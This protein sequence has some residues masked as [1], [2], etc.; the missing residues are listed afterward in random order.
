MPLFVLILFFFVANLFAAAWTGSTSEPENTVKVGGKIFYAITS[1]EELAWFAIQVNA[2]TTT[3]N[4]VLQ[5]D[6]VFGENTN[7]VG[8]SSWTPIGK[9]MA[10]AFNGIFDGAHHSIYGLYS[11]VR[12]TSGFIGVLNSNGVLKDISFYKGTLNAD[13]V[14]GLVGVNKGTVENVVNKS[15]T[16]AGNSSSGKGGIVG[17]NAGTVQ[18]C[19]N[20]I[21]IDGNMA[22]GIVGVNVGTTKD[23]ENS[24]KITGHGYVGG[25]C[26]KN[27]GT[28]ANDVNKGAI[29]ASVEISY[30]SY[31]TDPRIRCTTG[32]SGGA[33][34]AGGICAYNGGIVKNAKNSGNVSASGG[35]VG[36]IVGYNV[37]NIQ[38][39]V[40]SGSVD[41]D[42][43]S[44]RVYRGV[45]VISNTGKLS[46]KYVTKTENG[47]VGGLVG[48][49]SGN[50]AVLTTSFN[51]ALVTTT[52]AVKGGIA[53]RN[54]SSASIEN[55]YY[56]ATVLSDVSAVGENSASVKNV[57]GKTTANMKKDQFAW[58][59]NTNNGS[60]ANSGIWSRKDDYPIIS[61]SEYLP[62][63]KVTFDDDGATSN[64][65]S[66]YK[67]TVSIPSDPDAPNGHFFDGWYSGSTKVSPTTVFSSDQIVKAK[68]SLISY[69][70]LFKNYDGTEL[71]KTSFEYGS[72]PVWSKTPERDANE[73]WEYIF[74]GWSPSVDSVIGNAEYTAVFDSSRVKYPITFNNYDDT[75]LSVVPTEYGSI[76]AY[77][78]VPTRI[79]EGQWSY[80]F[81][82][83]T[84][85]LVAVT[86]PATYKAVYDS[87]I[88]KY[89]IV[90]KDYNG[91]IL[92]SSK[93]V[94]GNLPSTPAEIS[95][96]STAE[97]SYI[98]KGWNHEVVRVTEP[99]TYVAEYD[100]TKNLYKITFVN[101]D[102]TELCSAEFEYG[103]TP[104]CDKYPIHE[105]NAEWSYR[106]KNWSPAIESVSKNQDYVA[107]YD[108]SKV[109]Y[110]II[111]KNE[112][113][114]VETANVAYGESYVISVK[115][116]KTGY[117]FVGWYVDDVF[118]GNVNDRIVVKSNI[119]AEA[120]FVKTVSSSSCNSSSSSN[121]SSSSSLSETAESS[122]SAV[123][124]DTSSSSE[125]TTP[126]VVG[127][128]PKF[129][130]MVNGRNIQIS[131]ARIGAAYALFDMQGKVLLQG[132]VQTA[133][134]EILVMRAGSYLLKIEST[135][136]RVSVR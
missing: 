6:I 116:V 118:L 125:E 43:V 67:G 2:G 26:G 75:E 72:L 71:E 95:R 120:R 108:S 47:Y 92:Q 114:V 29:S 10:T 61:T 15:M 101:Y 94:Y 123:L 20:N 59:L 64:K 68:Y 52:K 37:K 7:T 128:A 98:F 106:F 25:I 18:S 55:T 80:S 90:F 82:G 78:G 46:C 62:I 14:G 86:E 34:Y 83:W 93:V 119:S 115:S 134:F 69:T 112:D 126:I 24:A 27:T 66:T 56:D 97:W 99:M 110:T 87:S 89:E 104:V 109:A 65:Y 129:S 70:I 96:T 32:S 50:A 103:N 12:D 11:T 58:I 5:N 22:G 19:V 73:V 23:C 81:K 48:V 105:A 54:I 44:Y 136:Q 63:Y 132:R 16:I 9:G 28:V 42:N 121:V 135:T 8:T 117:E 76:P 124:D 113:E 100:S 35:S 102:N 51:V 85:V 4:A 17:V 3:I 53:S 13:K 74:K 91:A 127:A 33:A 1:P 57:E 49:D 21:T 88:A 133:N 131:T 107:V 45:T 31:S 130:V 122:S 60:S 36:G 40:N 41:G 79:S 39:T 38:N 111:F 84:P 30:S 77:S